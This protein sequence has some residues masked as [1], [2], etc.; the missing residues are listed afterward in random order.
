M[1]FQR[2]GFQ[3]TAFQPGGIYVRQPDRMSGGGSRSAGPDAQVIYSEYMR[4]WGPKNPKKLP[5][6][7]DDEEAIELLLCAIAADMI[8]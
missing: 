8:H 5:V 6:Y 7:T 4:R 2:S 1:A 3:D